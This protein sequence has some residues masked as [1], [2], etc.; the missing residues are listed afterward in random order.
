MNATTFNPMPHTSNAVPTQSER[1]VAN[2]AA[3]RKRMIRTWR[4]RGSHAV[5]REILAGLRREGC[6]VRVKAGVG[7]CDPDRISVAI[8]PPFVGRVFVSP[9]ARLAIARLAQLRVLTLAEGSRLWGLAGPARA[10]EIL[11]MPWTR[12]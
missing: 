2:D 4:G 10:A 7:Y 6:T 12:Q 5:A 1:F 8:P 11:N 3:Y 9:F